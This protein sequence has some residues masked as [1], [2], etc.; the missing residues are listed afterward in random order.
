MNP[1]EYLKMLRDTYVPRQNYDY[2]GLSNDYGNSKYDTGTLA[3]HAE[4]ARLYGE[5]PDLTLEYSRNASQNSVKTLLNN[6]AANTLSVGTK[7][8]G[9]FETLGRAAMQGISYATSEPGEST[10][11]LSNNYSQGVEES[12]KDYFKVY[13][14]KDYDTATNPVAKLFTGYGLGNDLLDGAAFMASSIVG[15]GLFAKAGGKIATKLLVSNI[16][17]ESAAALS[18]ASKGAKIGYTVGSTLLEGLTE[19][20]Q[21]YQEVKDILAKQMITDDKGNVIKPKY[22]D[23]EVQDMATKSFNETFL[24]NAAIL[25]LSNFWEAGLLHKNYDELLVKHMK[26]VLAGDVPAVGSAVK[27]ALRTGVEGFFAEGVWEENMQT[28]IQQYEKSFAKEGKGELLAGVLKN[29]LKGIAD[30]TNMGNGLDPDQLERAYSITMGAALGIAGGPIM[31]KLGLDSS[32]ADAKKRAEEIHKDTTGLNLGSMLD[33]WTKQIVNEDGSINRDNIAQWALHNTNGAIHVANMLKA[34]EDKDI[35]AF[36][37]SRMNAITDYALQFKELS[38]GLDKETRDKLLD[39]LTHEAVVNNKDEIKSILDKYENLYVNNYNNKINKTIEDRRLHDIT[40]LNNKIEFLNKHIPEETNPNHASYMEF[41]KDQENKLA[42]VMDP[43]KYVKYFEEPKEKNTYAQ[44]IALRKAGI[45]KPNGY[46]TS[47]DLKQGIPTKPLGIDREMM[48]RKGMA[49]LYEDAD[50]LE[51]LAKIEYPSATAQA[52]LQQVEDDNRVDQLAIDELNN[53]KNTFQVDI[54][55]RN[56]NGNVVIDS[57]YSVEDE[58][59]DLVGPQGI[60]LPK[61]QRNELIKFIEARNTGRTEYN[62][63]EEFGEFHRM[64]TEEASAKSATASQ[65]KQ[66]REAN[67][68]MPTEA[69]MDEALYQETLEVYEVESLAKQPYG[70]SVTKLDSAIKMLRNMYTYY[71]NLF[72]NPTKAK[73]VQDYIDTLAVKREEVI[74]AAKNREAQQERIANNFINTLAV[75]FPH[76]KELKD[77]FTLPQA[78]IKARFNELIAEAKKQNLPLVGTEEKLNNYLFNYV[79]SYITNDMDIA[80]VQALGFATKQALIDYV[81]YTNETFLVFEE[82]S[83]LN[84]LLILNS[85][86]NTADIT[87]E[88]EEEAKQLLA[89]NTEAD[90]KGLSIQQIIALRQL[91]F[92]TLSNNATTTIVNGTAGTGKNF[93]V[94]F[95]VK[96]FPNKKFLGISAG[97]AITTLVPT[98]G[99]NKSIVASDADISL[100][101]ADIKALIKGDVLVIDEAY[102]YSNDRMIRAIAKMQETQQFDIVA[103]GDPSQNS[104]DDNGFFHTT[105]NGNFKTPVYHTPLLNVSYRTENTGIGSLADQFKSR[106]TQITSIVAYNNGSDKGS[107]TSTN[108]KDEFNASTKNKIFIDKDN[109]IHTQGLEFDEVYIQLSPKDF[110]NDFKKFNAAMYTSVTRAKGKVV[111][112]SN[113]AMVTASNFVTEITYPNLTNEFNGNYNIHAK[114]LPNNLP[115]VIIPTDTDDDLELEQDNWYNDDYHTFEVQYLGTS[116]INGEEMDKFKVHENENV[117]YTEFYE[118]KSF[119]RFKYIPEEDH[120]EISNTESN[121]L[122]EI[123]FP[124]QFTMRELKDLQI[125][126]SIRGT[127]T[128]SMGNVRGNTFITYGRKADDNL[129][130]VRKVLVTRSVNDPNGYIILGYSNSVSG[131]DHGIAGKIEGRIF[132]PRSRSPLTPVKVKYNNVTYSYKSTTENT[133]VWKNRITK[134]IEDAFTPTDTNLSFVEPINVKAAIITKKLIEAIPSLKGAIEKAKMGRPVLIY[135]IPA[136]INAEPNIADDFR[137]FYKGT[138][139]GSI[140]I[141][142][143]ILDFEAAYP[144]HKGKIKLHKESKYHFIDLIAKK[145]SQEDEEVKIFNHFMD[146]LSKVTYKG[147][148]LVDQNYNQILDDLVKGNAKQGISPIYGVD[149]DKILR[150][151]ES[152]DIDNHELL[153][154]LVNLVYKKVFINEGLT[155]KQLLKDREENPTGYVPVR[156]PKSFDRTVDKIKQLTK[157]QDPASIAEAETLLNLK[158]DITDNDGTVQRRSGI[159]KDGPVTTIIERIALANKTLGSDKNQVEKRNNLFIKVKSATTNVYSYVVHNLLPTERIHSDKLFGY[160]RDLIVKSYEGTSDEKEVKEAFKEIRTTEDLAAFITAYAKEDVAKLIEDIPAKAK[161]LTHTSMSIKEFQQYL[162]TNRVTKWIPMKGHIT[163]RL[164]GDRVVEDTGK[165]LSDWDLDEVEAN[166]VCYLD[167]I[168]KNRLFYTTTASSTKTHY[169]AGELVKPSYVTKFLPKNWTDIQIRVLPSDSRGNTDYAVTRGREITVY[170][171]D[172]NKVDPKYILHEIIHYYTSQAINNAKDFYLNILQ[173]TE[174]NATNDELTLF[175]NTR[176]IA[177]KYFKLTG[178]EALNKLAYSNSLVNAYNLEHSQIL[179]LLSYNKAKIV[180]RDGNRLTAEQKAELLA[181][182]LKEF[183]ANLSEKDFLEDSVMS[184]RYDKRIIPRI[185][186]YIRESINNIVEF[187]K[188][189]YNRDPSNAD[190]LLQNI[191]ELNKEITEIQETEIPEQIDEEDEYDE[192]DDEEFGDVGDFVQFKSEAAKAIITDLF[193]GLYSANTNADHSFIDFVNSVINIKHDNQLNGHIARV[194]YH[195]YLT[196][197]QKREIKASLNVKSDEQAISMLRK[198]LNDTVINTENYGE[199][200]EVTTQDEVNLFTQAMLEVENMIDSIENPAVRTLY[201]LLNKILNQVYNPIDGNQMNSE[202]LKEYGTLDAFR[203]LINLV[204]STYYQYYKLGLS[205]LDIARLLIE[206]A[207]KVVENPE[208][209]PIKK[210]IY[211][212]LLDINN[213]GEHNVV[214]IINNFI[215]NNSK[216]KLELEAEGEV[217]EDGKTSGVKS[218]GEMNETMDYMKSQSENIKTFFNFIRI[219]NLKEQR[220]YKFSQVYISYLRMSKLVDFDLSNFLNS[221]LMNVLKPLQDFNFPQ[222][223]LGQDIKKALGSHLLGIGLYARARK[224]YT[225]QMSDVGIDKSNVLESTRNALLPLTMPRSK[226]Y[227]K[228]NVVF[229]NGKFRNLELIDEMITLKII[230][231]PDERGKF[232]IFD[233]EE[234]KK[235]APYLIVTNTGSRLVRPTFMK[236]VATNDQYVVYLGQDA[237]TKSVQELEDLGY[238]KVTADSIEKIGEK[239]ANLKDPKIAKILPTSSLTASQPLIRTLVM[240]SLMFNRSLELIRD[241]QNNIHSLSEKTYSLVKNEKLIEAAETNKVVLTRSQLVFELLELVEDIKNGI[242]IEDAVKSFI[243]TFN[244]TSVSPAVGAVVRFI[245]Q[246][247]PADMNTFM[248]LL[249]D[250]DNLDIKSAFK[251]IENTRSEINEVDRAGSIKDGNNNSIFKFTLGSFADKIMTHLVSLSERF[252]DRSIFPATYKKILE[253][254]MLATRQLKIHSYSYYD[255]IDNSHK[256][257]RQTGKPYRKTPWLSTNKEQLHKLKFENFIKFRNLSGEKFDMNITLY[258]ISD[259]SKGIILKVPALEETE[260]FK[261]LHEINK[262]KTTNYMFSIGEGLDNSMPYDKFV[263]AVNKRLNVH[264]DAYIADLKDTGVIEGLDFSRFA[265]EEAA[266]KQF[267]GNY[268]VYSQQF[269]ELVMGDLSEYMGVDDILKRLAGAFGPGKTPFVDDLFGMPSKFKLFVIPDKKLGH[270]DVKNTFSQYDTLTPADMEFLLRDFLVEIKEKAI[271]MSKDQNITV[272][273]AEEQI[274]QTDFKGVDYTDAQSYASMQFY[275]MLTKGYAINENTKHILKPLYDDSYIYWKTSIL[276]LSKELQ[277]KYLTLKALNELMEKNNIHVLTHPS[278]LK[279]KGTIVRGD[280]NNIRQEDMMGLESKFFRLQLNPYSDSSKISMPSQLMYFLNFLSNDWADIANNAWANL[281]NNGLNEFQKSLE[282]LGIEKL[283]DKLK[284]RTKDLIRNGLSIFSPLI[285][286]EVLSVFTGRLKK[287]TQG[288]THFKKG[289]KAVL[290]SA[291][292]FPE[293]KMDF[294]EVER[295]GKKVKM[296][297][298]NIIAPEALLKYIPDM[299]AQVH[300]IAWR[301]PSTEIHSAILYRIIGTIPGDTNVII[302]PKELVFLH[303]SDKHQCPNKISLIAGNSTVR[304]QSAASL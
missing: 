71:T 262:N 164:D 41:L 268:I 65:A 197:K 92:N 48:R 81:K 269:T 147:I 284:P 104:I 183:L 218:L 6:I 132:T 61:A 8:V 293:V 194:I 163:Y 27:D 122:T 236:A 244:L 113:A 238:A 157:R 158:F 301:I 93:L 259:K 235:Y 251:L 214:N 20:Q 69:D 59:N 3:G 250:R 94:S 83:L 87:A 222:A 257:N 63:Y 279:R 180:D 304:G 215:L 143:A 178:E 266:V 142:K 98:K 14:N 53:D 112:D 159:R 21:T 134:E 271:E 28:A 246:K 9:G 86:I 45:E 88:L 182:I 278:A 292:H 210:V 297:V 75:T 161:E 225:L 207:S 277:N 33:T 95:L 226:D 189:T 141:N 84:E 171:Q 184:S 195:G 298:H 186:S 1:E 198:A 11:Y 2:R 240:T 229:L 227:N 38:E 115:E 78:K 136:V 31:T 12:I 220:F 188:N 46:L 36:E 42:E 212:K 166:H 206:E 26:N 185:L 44:R 261:K 176:S 280:L 191:S 89:I 148:P 272:E 196:E 47:D 155:V 109:Y 57:A 140:E 276:V 72:P 216:H 50:D 258:P 99:K 192:F 66:I 68:K 168:Q 294:V 120:V 138:L 102:L 228:N 290:A 286:K 116:I 144:Q 29:G 49:K 162:N 39:S 169:S 193:A 135:T 205:N 97:K 160:Y 170:T 133:K 253:R 303:G 179:K 232:D 114:L 56:P 200:N 25:S 177:K 34:I 105:Y 54:E 35:K 239:I 264:V 73:Q 267:I 296:P 208:A 96:S 77:I 52:T 90:K 117:P 103:I 91:Q 172:I 145:Y 219:S 291:D 119:R 273:E 108:I 274:K 175:F 243:T 67:K 106:W 10:D 121:D 247:R 118:P 190:V 221:G 7:F 123:E 165:G 248:K 13:R 124:S 167:S 80:K 302:A 252:A 139:K 16:A 85:L 32:E 18:A 151:G 131:I 281:L 263:G 230:S 79:F 37:F 62:V 76:V 137:D 209:D 241:L 126:E 154:S 223:G 256:I 74:N 245:N 43:K 30:F 51:T 254:N 110:N 23:D 5:N 203:E 111:I 233:S 282:T 255:S 127:T 55:S 213:N 295:D 234:F 242:A 40:Y 17:R 199:I 19:A 300:G 204:K 125:N 15:G 270:N 173:G 201:D 289:K 150:V 82:G 130:A 231:V 202:I 174:H 70:A 60:P 128:D 283:L 153:D 146:L 101:E 156:F 129:E 4:A 181:S 260:I 265:G 100:V 187:F 22:T 288:R 149:A 24:T 224:I 299:N 58:I 275:H 285:Y 249:E 107:F 217:D 237:D 211:S 287:E 152:E 64:K